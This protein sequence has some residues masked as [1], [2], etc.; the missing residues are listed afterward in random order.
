MSI[1]RLT[2]YRF[3]DCQPNSVQSLPASRFFLPRAEDPVPCSRKLCLP[4]S[5]RFLQADE[6]TSKLP[7]LRQHT[8]GMSIPVLPIYSQGV[9]IVGRYQHKCILLSRSGLAYCNPCQPTSGP[10]P[11]SFLSFFPY[12]PFYRDIGSPFPSPLHACLLYTSPS[13][14]DG[15]LSRMPSSA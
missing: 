12:S 1:N 14:R 4:R 6:V 3:L 2:A 8:L 11:P 15:L 13:P 7:R 5:P 9:H 10:T